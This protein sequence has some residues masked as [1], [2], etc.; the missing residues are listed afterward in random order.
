VY[1]VPH[2]QNAGQNHKLLTDNKSFGNVNKFKYLGT[3]VIKHNCIHAEIKSR[4]YLETFAFV[5]HLLTENSEIKIHKTV[6]LLF[7]YAF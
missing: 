4:L 5:S 6:I 1:G 3:A 7:L 2:Y